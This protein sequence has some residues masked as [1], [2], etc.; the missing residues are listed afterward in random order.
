M[1][2]VMQ[3]DKD[4]K[5]KKKLGSIRFENIGVDSVKIL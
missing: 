1:Y 3:D 4:K 5:D 2:V